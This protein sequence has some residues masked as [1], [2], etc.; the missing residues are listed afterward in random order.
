M[1]F[2]SVTKYPLIWPERWKRTQRPISSRFY[3]R[4]FNA[5]FNRNVTIA[6]AF[7]QLDYEI[8]QLGCSRF[9]LSTNLLLGKRGSP[10][11]GQPEPKDTGAAVYFTLSGKPTVLACDKWNRVADNVNAIAKHLEALRGQERWGVGSIEQAFMGY[12]ALPGIGE[13]GAFKW[14]DVLGVSINATED[15]VKEAYRILVRKHHP[16]LNGDSELFHRVQSAY[17]TFQVQLKQSKAA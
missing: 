9:V 4:D 5:R 2:E 13:S 11:S 6:D 1:D 3:R 12:Q 16:D 8:N 7:R 14:W 10:V 17:E 15:Q